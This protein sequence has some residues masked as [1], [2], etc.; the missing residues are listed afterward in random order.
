MAQPIKR[1]LVAGGG[2]A[3]LEAVLALSELVDGGLDVELLAPAQEFLYR[4]MLVAAP[5]GAGEA[6]RIDLHRAARDAGARH[7]RDAL[8]SVDPASRSVTTTAGRTLGYDALL[9]ALGGR[10]E[11][12]VPGALAFGGDEER[13]RFGELLAAL[14]RPRMKRLAFVVPRAATW[15]IAAYELALLTAAER[16]ARALQGVEIL[17]VTH[18]A[19]PLDLF[20]A[21]ASRQVAM[22]LRKAGVVLHLNAVAEGFD[23]R[24]LAIED[25]DALEVDAAVALPR[26]EVP[27]IPGIPQRQG[28]FVKTDSAMQVDGLQSVWA[29]GD[30]TWFPVKQGGLA[31]QQ[32]DVAARSI[33]ARSGAHVPGIPFQPILRG[34]LITGGAPEFFRASRA[35]GATGTVGRPLWWPPT[36]LA[37]LYLG[38]YLAG[39]L[40]AGAGAFRDITP[41]ADTSADKGSHERAVA[42]LLAAADADAAGG[43]FEGAI[44]WLSLVEELNLV[45]P[46]DHLARRHEWRRHLEPDAPPDPAVARLDPSLSGAAHALSDLQRRIGWLRALERGDEADLRHDLAALDEGMEQLMALGRRSGAV[47]GKGGR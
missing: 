14:G 16:D 7:T 45:I 6:L 22:R 1:V 15:A 19:G 27:P 20:G 17:L 24:R 18:E 39:S 31:A 44:R 8:A 23:G 37:G 25:G 11:E 43:E 5:F 2:V 13:R 34:A 4:P 41:P 47:E 9:L 40:D 10:P 28:G 21:A 46:P 32:A 29:A 26:L 30:M 12:A 33:A 35:G 38:P 3:G 36:K 42:I